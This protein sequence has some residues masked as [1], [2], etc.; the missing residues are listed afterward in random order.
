[1]IP[2]V[3][4]V[5]NVLPQITRK[6]IKKWAMKNNHRILIY[7]SGFIKL[8]IDRGYTGM[9]RILHSIIFRLGG[10][11]FR[12]IHS[13]YDYLYVYLHPYGPGTIIVLTW[14]G[15]ECAL[16]VKNLKRELKAKLFRPSQLY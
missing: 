1:M 7:R 12:L 5:S 6:K 11:F 16:A 10:I 3:D 4:I 13:E 9:Q 8:K 14:K 15:G 2:R